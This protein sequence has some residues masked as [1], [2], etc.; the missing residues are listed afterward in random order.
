MF[1]NDKVLT[2]VTGLETRDLSAVTNAGDV[3]LSTPLAN[4]GTLSWNSWQWL[5]G[6]HPVLG[7][8]RNADAHWGDGKGSL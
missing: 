2:N 1:S 8:A 4:Q 3:F 5:T 7:L 6:N